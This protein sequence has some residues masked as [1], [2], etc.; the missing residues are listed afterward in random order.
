MTADEEKLSPEE[1]L[2]KVIQSGGDAERGEQKPDGAAADTVPAQ[3]VARSSAEGA[4]RAAGQAEGQSPSP[5]ESSDM[6]QEP[7]APTGAEP[8]GR[9]ASEAKQEVAK[10][11]PKLKVAKGAP[12]AKQDKGKPAVSESKPVPAVIAAA[13]ASS[14]RGPGSR[15]TGIRTV[16]RCL[17]AIVF[18]MVCL[19]G[20]EIWAN[21]RSPE[22]EKPPGQYGPLAQIGEGESEGR[23]PSLESLLRSFAER[24]IFQI[25]DVK[26]IQVDDQRLKQKPPDWVEYTQAHFNLIGF[27]SPRGSAIAGPPDAEGKRE[28]IIVDKKENKMHF[29]RT[30]QE[31]SIEEQK[32]KLKEILKD[33]V[34]FTDGKQTVTVK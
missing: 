12:G 22:D 1:K 21:I 9:Q 19:A 8:S 3:P 30:G 15:N 10:P 5:G 16:N 14:G 29:L 11:K 2:L 24:D 7:A 20:F 25:P 32:L 13:P 6:A 31:L 26:V 34:V 27:S 18:I 17:A 33:S 4:A 28:A 23:V